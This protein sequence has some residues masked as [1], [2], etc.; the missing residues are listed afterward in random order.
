MNSASDSPSSTE[1]LLLLVIF[2]PPPAP[3]PPPPLLL[4][5]SAA[6]APPFH[7]SD[8]LTPS[9]SPLRGWLETGGVS[10][11][12]VGGVGGAGDG[13][14]A[15]S[16]LTDAASKSEPEKE[17]QMEGAAGVASLAGPPVS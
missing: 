6:F 7:A 9:L 14:A 1:L 3:P 11:R 12:V 16:F 5:G 10:S 2:P 15:G 17:P 13:S 8:P 4:D